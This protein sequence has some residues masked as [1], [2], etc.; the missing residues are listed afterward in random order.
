MHAVWRNVFCDKQHR[1]EFS[2]TQ[3]VCAVLSL[4]IHKVFLGCAVDRIARRGKLYE[5]SSRHGTQS[6]AHIVFATQA[7]Q[8]AEILRSSNLATPALDILAAFPYEATVVICHTDSTLLPPRSKWRCMNFVHA[9]PSLSSNLLSFYSTS[10]KKHLKKEY[11]VAD[12]SQCTHI[13]SASPTEKTIRTCI[14][15]KYV[16]QTTNAISIPD[17]QKTL[18][19]TWYERC[20]VTSASLRAVADMWGDVGD[21]F[22]DFKRDYVKSGVQGLDGIWFTGSYCWPGIPLLEG[23][24]ASARRVCEG[25]CQDEG[26]DFA[27]PWI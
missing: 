10:R 25:I 7:N 13:V 17:P 19:V 2:I 22:Y 14:G 1:S 16:F 21:G 23:C 3:H 20:V 8:A 11:N 4:P 15:G 9:N 27:V 12:I 18:A 24:V 26:I 6:Y 5:I